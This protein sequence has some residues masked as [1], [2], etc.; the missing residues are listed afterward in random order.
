MR[1]YLNWRRRAILLTNA[2]KDFLSMH[3]NVL[4]SLNSEPHLIAFYA[5]HCD[6]DVTSNV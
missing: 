5:K 6:G 2:V 3:G 4:G 1:K